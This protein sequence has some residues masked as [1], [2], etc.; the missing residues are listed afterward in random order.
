LSRGKIKNNK[1]FSLTKPTFVF[2]RYLG[3]AL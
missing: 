2:G 3:E 1:L